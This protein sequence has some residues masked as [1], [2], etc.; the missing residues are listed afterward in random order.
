MNHFNF[1]N[2]VNANKLE[3]GFFHFQNNMVIDIENSEF[4]NNE[5]HSSGI[6]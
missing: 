2:N 4:N 6:L 3:N 5:S 1:S